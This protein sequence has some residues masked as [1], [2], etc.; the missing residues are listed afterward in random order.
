MAGS[1]KPSLDKRL[2]HKKEALP[3]PLAPARECFFL[4]RMA[5]E[6]VYVSRSAETT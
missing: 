6:V 1:A 5:A 3:G 4:R 2:L